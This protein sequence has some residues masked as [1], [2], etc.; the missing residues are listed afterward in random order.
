MMGRRTFLLGLLVIAILVIALPLVIFFSH[1]QPGQQIPG[2]QSPGATISGSYP[3]NIEYNNSGYGAYNQAALTNSNIGAADVTMDWS[4]VEPQQGAFNWTKLDAELHEWGSVGKKL[5]I[6][7]R[8]AAE[9]GITTG[10]SCPSNRFLPVWEVARI[11]H[12]C[13]SDRMIVIPDYFDPTFQT[14][15]KAYVKAIADHIAQSPYPKTIIYVRIGLGLGG[16]GFPLMVGGRDYQLDIQQ[17]RTWGYTP[18]NWLTWQENLLLYYKSVFSY[19]T[20]IYPINQMFAPAS[21]PLNINPATGNPIQ[22]DV[23]YFAASH[24]MGVGQQGLAPNYPSDYAK[25]KEILSYITQHYPGTYI[26]LAAWSV[27][28]KSVTPTCDATCVV[29]GDIQTAEQYGARS[30]DWWAQDDTNPAFQPYFAQ[31]QQYVDSKFA[32]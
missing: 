9:S 32:R 17:L 28:S 2:Q 19:T 26:Q 10:T 15:L 11:Q 23:A 4:R 8:Y 14:D 1:K 5:V 6:I 29:Q 31:W 3:A 22:M 25:I 21:N 30:I 13:D 27:I 24:G 18:Q 16:E 7:I 12:F 20:I